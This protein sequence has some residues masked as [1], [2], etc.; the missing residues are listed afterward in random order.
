MAGAFGCGDSLLAEFS[1]TPI[2]TGESVGRYVAGCIRMVEESG[3]EYRMNPMGTVVRGEFDEVIAL[4]AR[5]HK[6]VRNSCKR[7]ST[8]IK[9]DDREGA[10]G[11]LTEK[12]ASVE[13]I[14]GR[15]LR[16]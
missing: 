8:V 15:R 12:V 16:T 6:A 9:I 4:I 3:L 14:L 11:A 1:V 2:G 5:C 10:E 13:R 7:V